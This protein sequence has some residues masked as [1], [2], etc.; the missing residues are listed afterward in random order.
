LFKLHGEA[1]SYWSLLFL[2][3]NPLN[4]RGWNVVTQNE[5]DRLLEGYSDKAREQIQNS[6]KSV[7]RGMPIAQER[8]DFEK[9]SL[10]YGLDSLGAS[11]CI[12]FLRDDSIEVVFPSGAL[13]D[14][15][16]GILS[17]SGENARS[18][19]LTWTDVYGS[20][21]NTFTT[22][23]LSEGFERLVSQAFVMNAG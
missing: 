15:P 19:S 18:I 14:D 4:K 22:E 5:I 2:G 3:P 16:D 9:R 17:G 6:R 23:P 21:V 20:P 7:F 11:L 1:S 10:I 13:L 8:I 12:I